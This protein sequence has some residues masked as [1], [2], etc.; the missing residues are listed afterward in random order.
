ME[1]NLFEEKMHLSKD[2]A[3]K[4]TLY[5]NTKKMMENSELISLP[6]SCNR[7]WTI[8]ASE[9]EEVSPTLAPLKNHAVNLCKE[10]KLWV[11]LKHL[12]VFLFF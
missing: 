2:F 6:Q 12:F 1:L 8:E 3:R 9:E 10:G 11:Y 5:H 7:F 4:I